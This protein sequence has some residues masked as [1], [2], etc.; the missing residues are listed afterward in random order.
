LV[1][2]YQKELLHIHRELRHQGLLSLKEA[3]TAGG[4]VEGAEIIRKLIRHELQNDDLAVVRAL[5][6]PK[7]T[8]PLSKHE[9]YIKQWQTIN[10][11]FHSTQHLNLNTIDVPHLDKNSQPTD[12]PERAKIWKTIYDPVMI[13]E[14]LLARNIAHFG[15]A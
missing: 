11:A 9:L 14:K 7:G 13:E 12:D 5:K 1:T 10:P 15:Q 8:P 2:K 3:R 4:N 6:N